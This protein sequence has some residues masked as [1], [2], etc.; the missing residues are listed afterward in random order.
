MP[1]TS[2]TSS[3]DLHRAAE[4]LRQA[5]RADTPGDNL[6]QARRV[7]DWTQVEMGEALDLSVQPDNYRCPTL[8]AWERD[9]RQP[10]LQGRKKIRHL[11]ETLEDAAG[12]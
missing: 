4:L 7:L 11:A 10:Q 9:V 5:A 6:R 3:E 2:G 12:N 1:D 8:S